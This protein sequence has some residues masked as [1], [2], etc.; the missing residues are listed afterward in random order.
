VHCKRR[1]AR[2]CIPDGFSRV[3]LGSIVCNSLLLCELAP[4]VELE[5]LLPCRVEWNPDYYWLRNCDKI[6]K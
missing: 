2:V 4:K 3:S 6:L 1:D 5:I